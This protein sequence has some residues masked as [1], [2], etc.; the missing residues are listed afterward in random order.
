M[1]WSVN[2]SCRV[3]AAPPAIT[4]WRRGHRA[5]EVVT[6]HTVSSSEVRTS[7]RTCISVCIKFEKNQIDLLS[8]NMHIDDLQILILKVMLRQTHVE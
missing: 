8:H 5:G 2:I 6:G 3:W 1:G 4:H 7:T